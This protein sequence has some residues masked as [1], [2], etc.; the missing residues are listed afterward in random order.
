MAHEN[1]VHCILIRVCMVSSDTLLLAT[2]GKFS[3]M[4]VASTENTRRIFR[5]ATDEG[6]VWSFELCCECRELLGSSLT[7]D[8]GIT[9]VPVY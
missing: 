4:R 8:Y 5:L 1:G 7:I 3:F 6:V 2:N 9:A